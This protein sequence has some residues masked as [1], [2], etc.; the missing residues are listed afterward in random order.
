MTMGVTVL[1]E[2]KYTMLGARGGS[3]KRESADAEG[4]KWAFGT[5]AP[6]DDLYH[7]PTASGILVQRVLSSFM[8]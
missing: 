5:T 4:L 8:E 1:F 7:I 2:P 3:C 6:Q